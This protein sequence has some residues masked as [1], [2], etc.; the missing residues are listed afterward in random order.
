LVRRVEDREVAD[1]V[2]TWP[3]RFDDARARALGFP[4]HESLEALLR[5]FL[6]DDLAATRALRSA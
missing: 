6:E 3:A 5:A 1:I 4:P 2:G